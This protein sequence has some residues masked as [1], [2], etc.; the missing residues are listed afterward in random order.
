MT[1]RIEARILE[2]I[3][4]LNQLKAYD[5]VLKD[6]QKR[7]IALCLL[8]LARITPD[9]P[10]A[11]A[12]Y[13]SE[14]SSEGASLATR[15]I[16]AYWNRHYQMNLSPGSYD[17]VRRRSL[18]Y[19]MQAQLVIAAAGK[20]SASTNDPTRRYALT[21]EAGLLIQKY[22]T[23]GW[24]AGVTNFLKKHGDYSERIE[25]RRN[26]P[27]VP[28]RLPSGKVIELTAGEHN[29]I[30]KSIIQ[31]FLPRFLKAPVVL[32]IGDTAK[33]NLHIEKE[34]LS[35]LGIPEP[36]HGKL[37]DIIAF[38]N[39]RQWIFLIEAVHSSNPISRTRHIE[40][41]QYFSETKCPIVFV[42]AFKDRQSFKQWVIDISWETEVWIADH[43]EHM[44]HFNGDKFLGP[45]P[46]AGKSPTA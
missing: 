38:D 41:Q 7:R 19:L 45:Y 40:L 25:K 16:I 26:L 15:E 13:W 32:Y 39:A 24:A 9:T 12:Q 23:R 43:P 37:P 6:G 3:D 30:Q 14:A 27:V 21:R 1:D 11:Q 18:I 36:D 34:S 4:I 10:W 35:S 46:H 28:V 8:A 5:P 20:P 44:I 2:A 31:D 17:D 22:G 42:S 29:D 33:K